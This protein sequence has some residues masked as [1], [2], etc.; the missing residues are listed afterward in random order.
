MV[1]VPAET[2]VTA[3]D[4][5]IVVTVATDALPLLHVP[6]GVALLSVVLLPTHA[7]IVPVIGATAVG[8]LT[9]IILV[10]TAEPQPFE[11]V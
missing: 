6:D 10:A 3:T 4:A 9:V 8:A 11:T 5:P 7:D 2:P 1:A